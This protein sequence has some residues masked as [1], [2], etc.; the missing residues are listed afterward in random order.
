MMNPDTTESLTSDSAVNL[1][2]NNADL[3]TKG[4]DNAQEPQDTEV[5][6]E[7]TETIESNSE[8]DNQ[9]TEE[10]NQEIE[11]VESEQND[12]E[13]FE[14][15]I[16]VYLAKVDG[17]EVEVTADELIKSYQLETVAQKRLEE[18]KKTLSKSK[19]DAASI[20][21]ERQHY[22]QNLALLEQQ[23][24]QSAQGNATPEQWQE[25]YNSDPIAYMKA[26]EDVRD[27]QQRLAAVQ[28]EQQVLAQR[29]VENEQ[30]KLLDRIPEWK[31]PDVAAKEKSSIVT[32]A[33]NFGF[34]DSELANANDSR[35]VD[36]LRKAYLYD[37]LQGK[38]PVMQK[39]VNNAP[40][41]LKSSQPKRKANVAQQTK[42][43]AFERVL[44]TGSK[45]DAV[46][47]L[48]SKSK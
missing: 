10:E 34:S 8:S 24:A 47:Y 9:I 29:Y 23:L 18:A 31:N 36:L 14:E 5:S 15:E 19:E 27:N 33:K 21:Q 32:Y 16:P 20:E 28:Q 42:A 13:S 41:M 35:V 44:K 38:K 37:Q 2:L 12:E 4:L 17:E 26:K 3:Q 11:E 43:T 45:D 30:V 46:E 7:E 22:A 40:K 48:L 1:L 25:L 6:A 39:K